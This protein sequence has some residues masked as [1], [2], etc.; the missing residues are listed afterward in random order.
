MLACNATFVL[1]GRL[2]TRPLA[3]RELDPA[4]ADGA[5]RLQGA[6]V[7]VWALSESVA[8]Q[9]L[10]VWLLS[11]S[12]SLLLSFLGMAAFSFVCH[13]PR[14]AV[15]SAPPTLEELASGRGTIG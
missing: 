2:I 8:V 4:S 13:A 7:L 10:L 12:W 5:R 15:L 9:G 14:N 1:R 11:G 6:L 3:S